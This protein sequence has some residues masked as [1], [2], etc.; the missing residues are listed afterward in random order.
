MHYFVYYE[1]V[2]IKAEQKKS[3]TMRS[4]QA[5]EADALYRVIPGDDGKY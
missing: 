5:R 4:G 2:E 1:N 3:K